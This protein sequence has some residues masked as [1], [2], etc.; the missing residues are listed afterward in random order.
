MATGALSSEE[1]GITEG[2]LEEEDI[3]IQFR[4]PITDSFG[5][6]LQELGAHQHQ[7]HW[8]ITRVIAPAQHY[9]K[10]PQGI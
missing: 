2:F 10:C 8:N 6:I 9:R 3:L 7:H 4:G 5:L 1:V